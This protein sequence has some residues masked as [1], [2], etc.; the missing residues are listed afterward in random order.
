MS[1]KA[2]DF[3][4]GIGGWALGF[5]LAGV[6]ISDSYE[7]WEP[8]AV[9]HD[10][11]LGLTTHQKD[12]RKLS[13]SEIPNDVDFLVGSPPCTQ[14]SYSNRGGS[15]DLIDGL[16]DIKKFLEMVKHIRPKFWA[17]E[18]VPRVAKIIINELSNDGRL[19]AFSDILDSTMVHLYDFSDFGL[20]QKRKRCIVGNFNYQLLDSYK[21]NLPSKNLNDVILA[22]SSN[23]IIDPN[24]QIT[25]SDEEITEQEKESPLNWEEL[26]F[27]KEA[28]THHPIYNNMQFP[29]SLDKPARTI[30]ATCTRVSRESLIISDKD[31]FRRLT[32]RERGTLQGFPINYQFHGRSYAS[33]L[34]MIGNAIPPVF[35]YYLANAMLG[36][37]NNGLIPLKEKEFQYVNSNISA[38]ETLPETAGRK[39]PETRSFRFAIPNLRFKSGTRFELNNSYGKLPWR[40]NFFFGNSKR[41]MSVDLN[42]E[43]YSKVIQ[44]LHI[45]NPKFAEFLKITLNEK[46][47][48]IDHL[49]LQGTWSA[50]DNGLHPFILIDV[51]GDISKEIIDLAKLEKKELFH[52]IIEDFVVNKNFKTD[53]IIASKKL[54]D[55]ACDIV[56]GLLVGS[57]FNLKNVINVK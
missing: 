54:R 52:E 48:K 18:N 17:M 46:I 2:I 24:F 44:N 5:K 28:K 12:I 15:G 37:S 36:I 55:H 27:N 21:N 11:N 40:V 38:P 45:T 35:T 33:K 53:K 29:D 7:W 56:I 26:R 47:P 9:T 41:I 4:S 31:I 8:A 57:A 16:E 23:E 10:I 25:L 34:K 49:R 32:V 30:T 20:P 39:Y 1:P 3:Y 50:K 22:L 13:P 42:E 51:L 6:E 43:T 14:F 19:S